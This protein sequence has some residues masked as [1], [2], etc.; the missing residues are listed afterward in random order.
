[1][2]DT[3]ILKD[4]HYIDFRD[5]SESALSAFFSEL[6]KA[7]GRVSKKRQKGR[8]TVLEISSRVII[9]GSRVC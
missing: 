6:V 9:T 7:L 3:F 8:I 1:M 5:K 4:I 2:R